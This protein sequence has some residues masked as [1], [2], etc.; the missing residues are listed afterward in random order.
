MTATETEYFGSGLGTFPLQG[1]LSCTG[2]L[3]AGAISPGATGADNVL[4]VY[5]LPANS[6]DGA[7]GNA[8]MLQIQA[9]GSFA[10]NTNAKTTKIIF[11]P[12]TAVVGSTVGTGGTTIATS[13][14]YS[15][16][17]ACGWMLQAQVAK[18]GA[19]N[20]NTQVAQ[21]TATIVAAT[22]GG[23][24]LPVYPVATENAPILIAITGNAAT[25]AT[26]ILLNFFE[27]SA[28]N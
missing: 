12:S 11:N 15:T 19:A 1:N 28:A 13:G 9:S 3:A 6:F 18:V 20:S 24:G 14:V 22:H 27:V 8:R 17:G 23:I 2:Y 26:D 25:T 21:E 4:A 7:P 10:N 5:S 16:T